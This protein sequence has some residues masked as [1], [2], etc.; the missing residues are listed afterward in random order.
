[1]FGSEPVID[2]YHD[3]VGAHRVL[4]RRPVVGF[5]VTYDE[6]AAVKIQHHGRSAAVLATVGM[7]WRPI[8]SERNGVRGAGNRAVLHPQLGMQRPARQIAEPL[9]CCADS[10]LS[11]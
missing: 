5:E 4:T 8:D 3:R 1:M 2:G 11:G 10:V 9:A 6:A 7:T